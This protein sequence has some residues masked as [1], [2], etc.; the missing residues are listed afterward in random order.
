MIHILIL[1]YN[2]MSK[3]SS[4]SMYVYFDLLSVVFFAQLQEG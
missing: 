3:M 4:E 2:L 1:G